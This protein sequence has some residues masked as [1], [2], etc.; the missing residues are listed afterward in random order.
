MSQPFPKPTEENITSYPQ[1]NII[2]LNVD[3]P[4]D[5]EIDLL[6]IVF[7]LLDKA[8][9][10]I[11]S[12][13]I[14]AI[15][16]NAYSYFMIHPTYETTAKMYIV[17]ASN[18]S[19][20]DL[21]DLNIGTSLTKDYEELILSWP[22]LEQ[23]IDELDLE[24]GYKDLSKMLSVSNPSDT[25]IIDITVTSTSPKQAQDIANTLTKVCVKYLPE[26]MNTDKPN[27]A[28]KA[29]LPEQKVGPSY[30]KYTM[31]GAI[32]GFIIF[33]GIIVLGY[34]MDDTIH[35]AEDMEKYFGL[36]PLT[37]IPEDE[38]LVEEEEVLERSL[39]KR[40]KGKK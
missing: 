38:K 8:H 23:V 30:L 9:Y 29:K 37:S 31:I 5:D 24:M 28:Q 20:V 17:S 15:L 19:V 2:P 36:I 6:E 22:V 27:I 39:K 25:R 10:L 12:C 16:L 26:T 4:G 32:L 34:I 18:D 3:G 40:R 7:R 11:L 13:L 35:S 14:G 21:T 33:A 1:S